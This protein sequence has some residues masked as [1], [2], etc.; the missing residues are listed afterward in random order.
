MLMETRHSRLH[1]PP[2][3]RISE[4]MMVLCLQ[5]GGLPLKWNSDGPVCSELFKLGIHKY[6]FKKTHNM[7]IKF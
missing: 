6:C 3:W 7:M 1:T 4:R 2:N 5:Q